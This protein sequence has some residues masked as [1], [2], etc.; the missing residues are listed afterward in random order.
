MIGDRSTI[1]T[2]HANPLDSDLRAVGSDHH[3]CGGRASR[4][5]GVVNHPVADQHPVGGPGATPLSVKSRQSR[6]A[7]VLVDS[8][9]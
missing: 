1:P 7:Q 8:V 4:L 5:L 9:R 3:C 2:R 6:E